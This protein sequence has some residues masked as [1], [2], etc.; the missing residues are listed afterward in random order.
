MYITATSTRK[1]EKVARKLK[2]DSLSKDQVLRL[3]AVIEDKVDALLARG[4][5]PLR[6]A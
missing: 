2:V 1:V 3:C 4:C 5:S 6:F